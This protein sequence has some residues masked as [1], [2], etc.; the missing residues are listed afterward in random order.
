[1]GSKVQCTVGT[2]GL[3]RAARSKCQCNMTL[4]TDRGEGR[5][6]TPEGSPATRDIE[7]GGHPSAPPQ[8]KTDRARLK[9]PER[10]RAGFP[11][12]P[13]RFVLLLPELE[14]R[15]QSGILRAENAG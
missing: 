9:F 11:S 2:V 10:A 15:E 4:R 5:R 8:L 1:M 3:R 14:R 12:W 7:L 13:S 6:A